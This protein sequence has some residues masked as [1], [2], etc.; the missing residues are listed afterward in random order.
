MPYLQEAD[1]KQQLKTG[2]LQNL[3]VLYGSEG[4]LKQYYANTILKAAVE[5][6]MEGFNLKKFDADDGIELSAVFEAAVDGKT[7]TCIVRVN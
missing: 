6:S 2:S 4:Y 1:L 5:E 7:F 3:Y